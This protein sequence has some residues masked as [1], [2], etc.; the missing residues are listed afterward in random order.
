MAEIFNKTNLLFLLDGIKLTLLIAITTI[1]I[2]CILGTV[3]GV[4]KN[5]GKGL[6]GKLASIYIEVFRN[7]PLLLWILAIRFL[8]PIKPIYSGILSLSLFTTAIVAEIVRGGLRSVKTGQIEASLS[9]GFSKFQILRYII[10]PQAFRN[11]IPALLSQVTTIIKDTAFLW[12]VGIED[13]TGKGMILMGSFRTST[14]VFV[15]FAF[16]A[17]TYFLINF[18]IS[19]VVRVS[20]KNISLT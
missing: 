3:L 1:I 12:V 6:I 16:M 20:R 8:V 18:I 9:Q 4:L 19:F 2:S 5:Y 13:F 10:L 15:M 17:L 14:E 7:T 11:M